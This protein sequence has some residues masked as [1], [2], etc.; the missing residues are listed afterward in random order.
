M[1]AARKHRLRAAAPFAAATYLPLLLLPLPGP[2]W[3]PLLFALGMAGFTAIWA[4]VV[5]APRERLPRSLA[6]ATGVAYIALIALLRHSG[7]GDGSGLGLMVVLP[8]MWFALHGRALELWSAVA[9]SAAVYWIPIVLDHGGSA[10]PTSGWRTG[11]VLLA[12]SAIVATTVQR[13]RLRLR[14]QARRLSELAHTDE[15]TGLPNRR[16]WER[17]M[18]SVAADDRDHGSP[19]WCVAVVDLDGFKEF[20]DA[21]GHEAGDRLLKSV[22]AAWREQLRRDD[23]LVR[24]GGDEFAIL[25]PDAD[26]GGARVVLE[27]LTASSHA[28]CSIGVAERHSDESASAVLRRA[29]LALYTAKRDGRGRIA[30]AA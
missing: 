7:G 3:D 15:L 2:S 24:L 13:L 27:R 12:I 11:A 17:M 18:D 9:G 4:Y 21:N 6:V 16:G 25:M 19:A 28:N 22:A 14:E 5:L 23:I 29:D 10:Y 20:N 1:S 30:V 8:V 26:A